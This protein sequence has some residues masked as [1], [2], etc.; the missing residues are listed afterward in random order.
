MWIKKMAKKNNIAKLLEKNLKEK[1]TL[2]EEF[3]FPE[4]ILKPT[5][6]GHVLE[7]GRRYQDWWEELT[8]S[9]DELTLHMCSKPDSLTHIAELYLVAGQDNHYASSGTHGQDIESA[10]SYLNS[11]GF[12]LRGTFHSHPSFGCFFSGA[13]DTVNE[14]TLRALKG[15]QYEIV[16]LKKTKVFDEIPNLNIEQ[17]KEARWKDYFSNTEFVVAKRKDGK[18]EF[19]TEENNY[20]AYVYAIVINANSHICGML[21][22][23][24]SNKLNEQY[25]VDKSRTKQ[26]NYL[27]MKL[28]DT[29]K[30]NW[31]DENI[32]IDIIEKQDL[33]PLVAINKVKDPAMRL[34]LFGSYKFETAYPVAIL[35]RKEV[36][37]PAKGCLKWEFVM[38]DSPLEYAIK[39]IEANYPGALAKMSR[40]AQRGKQQE[41]EK[42]EGEISDLVYD[43]VQP[44][45]AEASAQQGSLA[46]TPSVFAKPGEISNAKKF[47][48]EY[49]E[50]DAAYA[51]LF[52]RTFGITLKAFAGSMYRYTLKPVVRGVSAGA[53]AGASAVYHLFKKAKK[54]QD[55]SKESGEDKNDK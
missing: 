7:K 53:S 3:V 11:I 54:D 8:G 55:C 25:S 40:A 4:K 10:R 20:V 45:K 51:G 32:I 37:I 18:F 16:K 27:D 14:N 36:C 22:Q 39:V 42:Q 19:S 21:S 46:E 13:D 44:A 5:I 43:A 15:S 26:G 47:S 35:T 29:E 24:I 12:V 17:G 28:V 1:E 2:K 50:F 38:S 6:E 48:K 23:R 34:K 41:K 52:K 49:D 33:D 30:K 31:A 9:K